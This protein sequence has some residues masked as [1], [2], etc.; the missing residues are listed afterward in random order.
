MKPT[1]KAARIQ[2]AALDRG[3]PRMA[4]TSATTAGKKASESSCTAR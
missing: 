4:Q 1:T 3:R 2:K